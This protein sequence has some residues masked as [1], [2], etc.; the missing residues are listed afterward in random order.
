MS[1]AP[2]ILSGQPQDGHGPVFREPWEAQAF[3]MTVV[4]HEQGLFSWNEWAEA[5]A[6]QISTAQ[7]AG[8][9]DLG[10][11]Y[12]CHW[13]AALEQLV[14]AKGASSIQELTRYQQA[15]SHAGERTPHGQPVDL[16]PADFDQDIT[17]G[18]SAVALSQ[19]IT[20]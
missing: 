19:R 9:S 3:A 17:P 2:A 18:G 12:Y 15:W 5:L 14:A 4:L 7:A 16:H 20:S 10:D 13:L 6:V 8:D 11:T 1:L